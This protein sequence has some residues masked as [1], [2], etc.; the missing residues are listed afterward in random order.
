MNGIVSR[1]PDVMRRM[2]MRIRREIEALPGVL[3]AAI[4][5]NDLRRVREVFVNASAEAHLPAMEGAV[6]GVLRANGLTIAEDGLQVNVL[7]PAAASEPPRQSRAFVFE[8]VDVTRSEGR[9][10]CRVRLL[11]RHEIVT[12]EATEPDS[13]SGSARAA[14]RAVLS[15]AERAVDD[16]RLGLE[17]CQIVELFS[18][19]YVVLSV[20]AIIARRRTIL[21]GIGVID[22]SAEDAACLAALGAIDRWLG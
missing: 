1:D 16:I 15:A 18:R 6:H 14:A 9:A 10:M 22:R 7:R 13:A 5:L 2:E 3:A 17:G 11:H 20:E 21:S 12:G 8:G 4:W 19:R